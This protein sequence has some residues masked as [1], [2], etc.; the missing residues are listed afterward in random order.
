LT[1]LYTSL[2]LDPDRAQYWIEH[3]HLLRAQGRLIEAEAAYRSA[4]ARGADPNAVG[5]DLRQVMNSLGVDEQD[6]PIRFAK[7]GAS[8][9]DQVPTQTDIAALARLLWGAEAISAERVIALLRSSADIAGATA[10]MIADPAFL[11]NPV[12]QR[13]RLARE[14]FAKTLADNRSAIGN[15]IAA[16]HEDVRAVGQGVAPLS[17]YLANGEHRAARLSGSYQA[18]AD[19]LAALRRELNGVRQLVGPFA[20][21][22]PDGGMLTQTIHGVKYFV[23]PDDLIM[24]PQ[25]VVYRQWEAHLSYLFRGLCTPDS[26]VVDVG[27][28]FGYFTCLAGTLIGNRG[29]GRVFAFEPNPKLARLARKNLEINWSM[30]PITLHEVAVADFEGE[31]TLHIPHAHG[32]NASLTAG[33]DDDGDNVVVRALRLDDILPDDVPVDVLKIDVEGH[34]LGVLKGARATVARSPAIR[35][36]MEWSRR[37]MDAAGIDPHDILDLLDG[38]TCYTIEPG[39][40][41]FAHPQSREWLLAQDYVDVMFA[42]P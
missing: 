10:L 3:G 31:V 27:A 20:A 34:E 19:N 16:L 35:I 29:R 30:A 41:P 17:D 18:I 42:R 4:C 40:D 15:A 36:I 9:L 6:F 2:A 33:A 8:G 1:E 26:I 24:T 23:D 22:F 38:M 7:P 39:P 21:H 28:N 25:M 32:A 11:D 12:Y 13:D 37:Q 14:S 5:D